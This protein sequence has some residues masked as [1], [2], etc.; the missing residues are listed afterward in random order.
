LKTGILA[1]T[2]P[3]LHSTSN[4]RKN[5]NRGWNTKKHDHNR[6]RHQRYSF[7]RVIRKKNNAANATSITNAA[8]KTTIVYVEDEGMKKQLQLNISKV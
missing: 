1:T 2:V 5:K 6:N 8:I 4:N 3:V 7:N